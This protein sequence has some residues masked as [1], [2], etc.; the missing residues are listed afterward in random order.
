M[1]ACGAQGC[2]RAKGMEAETLAICTQSVTIALAC[3]YQHLSTK[4]MGR[5][6]R[7]LTQFLLALAKGISCSMGIMP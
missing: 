2:G 4:H 7:H 3:F 1:A 6:I 5:L